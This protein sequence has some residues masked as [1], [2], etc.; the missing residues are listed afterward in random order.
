MK[1]LLLFLSLIIISISAKSQEPDHID[2]FYFQGKYVKAQNLP[3]GNPATDSIVVRGANGWFSRIAPLST[4]NPVNF[5]ALNST[6]ST[7]PIGSAVY[8]N[9]SS[10]G[11]PTVALA[12]AN[13]ANTTVAIGITTQA[14]ASGSTGTV[15]GIGAV[16]GLNTS[17][18]S[19]GVIYLSPTTPGS[20]TQTLP[21]LLGQYRYRVGFVTSVN[22][23]TGSIHITP[24]TAVRV[25]KVSNATTVGLN[26]ATL[27]ST[28]AGATLGDVVICDGITL[29]G[30][31]YIKGTSDKWVIASTP[32]V[33]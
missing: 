33:L 24:A 3:V 18:F 16:T 32:N 19:V 14:I 31:T 11:I 8:I 13:S 10:S 20:L 2:P 6:G 4:T 17:S 15:T 25:D 9:G 21:A 22:A 29:G 1:N 23:T 28:Y 5:I 7:I 12:Q 27:N 30:A 26:K